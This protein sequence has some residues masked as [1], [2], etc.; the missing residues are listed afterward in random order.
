[1]SR[2]CEGGRRV[3]V[4]VCGG[5]VTK[6]TKFSGLEGAQA[7]SITNEGNGDRGR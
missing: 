6:T 1:M 3:C 4:C 5:G 7:L 2:G